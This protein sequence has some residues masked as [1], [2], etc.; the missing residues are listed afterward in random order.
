MIQRRGSSAIQHA[1]VQLTTKKD[2][3]TLQKA[4]TLQWNNYLCTPCLYSKSCVILFGCNSNVVRQ[5]FEC[6]SACQLAKKKIL[7]YSQDNELHLPPL[8]RS[9]I[10]WMDLSL[11]WSKAAMLVFEMQWRSLPRTTGLSFGDLPVT[12]GFLDKGL[13][14]GK[15]LPC[16]EV[17]MRWHN[18]K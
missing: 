13:F 11:K 2:N 16:H 15:W 9:K 6:F 18:Q 17:I 1:H 3:T 7:W 14:T 8:V 10:Y 12:G 4:P 5:L